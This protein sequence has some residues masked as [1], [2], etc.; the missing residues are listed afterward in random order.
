[1]GG[2][3]K[4]R[5]SFAPISSWRRSQRKGRPTPSNRRWTSF[6]NASRR[7]AKTFAGR[8]NVTSTARQISAEAAP[9]HPSATGKESQR[10][11]G[12]ASRAGPSGSATGARG[13]P[14]SSRWT[15]RRLRICLRAPVSVICASKARIRAEQK[16]RSDLQR[17]TTLRMLAVLIALSLACGAAAAVTIALSPTHATGAD[18]YSSELRTN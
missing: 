18:G 13:D 4:R 15:D 2:R 14:Y 16:R 17:V 10:D 1:M 5:I 9:E 8:D 7:S 11:Q 6:L 12:E 3:R